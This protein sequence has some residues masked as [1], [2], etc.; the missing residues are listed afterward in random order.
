MQVTW[1]DYLSISNAHGRFQDCRRRCERSFEHHRAN[2]KCAVEVT[3]PKTVACLGAGVL[4]DIPY[5]AIVRSGA[6]LHL[7]DWVRGSI[8]AGV[9]MS[10][11]H[12][13][14]GGTPHCLYCSPTI[15]CPRSFCRRFEPA[16][17]DAAVCRSFVPIQGQPMRCGA[18]ERGEQPKVHYQDVTAGYASEFGREIL[19]ELRGVSSWKQ[20]FARAAG[21]V[22]RIGRAAEC[23]A[24]AD[25]SVDLVTSSMVV[26][27]FDHEP[28]D[29]FANRTAEMLGP[30]TAKEE[31]QLRPTLA[32]LRRTL[33]ANQVTRHCREI[34]RILAPG[35]YCYMSFEMYH[36]LP[37]D[38]HW[39][40]VDGMADALETLGRHF[41]FNFDIIPRGDSLARFETGDSPS[42]VC[43]FML[44]PKASE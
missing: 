36:R 27:Q 31:K 38:P 29:Y 40:L 4:S 33:L 12:T 21:L 16:T 1:D 3:K 30:P 14:E 6:S 23:T 41:H 5:D 43:S 7:V 17:S 37:E 2:I 44:A 24:I 15:E 22:E 34:R 32:S 39:F 8:D 10:I 28:Y 26:S 18:F 13:D 35:G 9:D 20:A 19:G 25:S 11:I 42:L